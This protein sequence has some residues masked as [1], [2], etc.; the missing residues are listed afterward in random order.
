MRK[1]KKRAQRK[2]RKSV[3]L[4]IAS[5]LQFSQQM[6]NACQA[7]RNFR[8]SGIA[9]PSV[10]S[11]RINKSS[12]GFTLIELLVVIAIISILASMLFPAFSRAR[13]SA[14]RISCVSNLKQIS[15]GVMQYTQDYDER[16]PVG[17]PFWAIS[18]DPSLTADKFLV[19]TVDPYLKSTQ[20]WDCSS[21]KGQYTTNPNYVGNYSYLTAETTVNNLFGAGSLI[22]ASL[23]AVNQPAEHALLFCG[24]APNQVASPSSLNAHSSVDDA[25]WDAGEAQGGTNIAFADGHVKYIPLTRGKWDEIYNRPR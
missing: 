7:P 20:I 14:R 17:Y 8:R 10:S 19:Q 9:M 18:V 15:L 4:F 5:F 22:P 2:Q 1:R 24:A 6:H 23:A 11:R 3:Q 25:K 21:W 13:E 16:Y 12:R